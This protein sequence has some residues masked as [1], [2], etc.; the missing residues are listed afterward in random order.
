MGKKNIVIEEKE[1]LADNPFPVPSFSKNIAFKYI[2]F[3]DRL[4]NSPKTAIL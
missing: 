1:L 4:Q 3:K 2:R